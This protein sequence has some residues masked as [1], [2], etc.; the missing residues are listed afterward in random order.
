MERK[1][2]QL[3]MITR[4][5]GGRYAKRSKPDRERQI[6]CDLTYVWNLKVKLIETKN[7]GCRGGG[8]GEMGWSKGTNFYYKTRTFWGSRVP[9]GDSRQRYHIV[10]LTVAKPVGLK[11]SQHTHSKVTV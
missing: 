7:I 5:P 3:S 4:E 2:I 6:L 8:V 1:E 10:C 11:C 9:H